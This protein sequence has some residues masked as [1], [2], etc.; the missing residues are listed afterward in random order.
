MVVTYKEESESGCSIPRGGGI[1]KQKQ[2]ERDESSS[3]VWLL[4]ILFLLGR[5]GSELPWLPWW[6]SLKITNCSERLR[7][8]R[9]G[10]KKIKEFPHFLPL[11]RTHLPEIPPKHIELKR[12]GCFHGDLRQ[13]SITYMLTFASSHERSLE[14]GNNFITDIGNPF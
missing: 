6:N 5:R 9:A 7:Y 12:G 8:Y 4:F 3:E 10:K 14:T 2:T 11:F 13:H 1:E